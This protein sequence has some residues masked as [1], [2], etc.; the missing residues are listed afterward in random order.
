MPDLR[1]GI[2]TSPLA[3]T[4]AGTARY[5]EALL[6]WLERD[7]ALEV[8]RYHFGAS[9]RPARIARDVGWYLAALPRLARRDGVDV[10]HCP[11]FRAPLRSPLPLV[12]TVH[13][14]AVLRHPE[15]FNRWARSYG[16]LTLPQVA[17]SATAIIAVSE[18]TKGEVVELLGVPAQRV[19]VVRHGVARPFEPEG[20]AGD[21]DYVLAV[22]TIEPR[23]NLARLLDG[24]RR[25]ALNGTELR[26]AGARGWGD[27]RV[28]AEG[29]RWLGEV[30]DEELARLYRGARCLAYV[31]LYEGFGLPI[32]EAMA[33]GTPVVTTGWG[34]CAEVAGD[35]AVL[36]DALDPDAIG[37]GL[38]EAAQ[39]HDELSSK[40][41]KRAREFTWK[42]AAG[43]TADV[44]RKAAG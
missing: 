18:F 20:P 7:N 13:D 22:S 8:V 26:I 33:C 25:A 3:L 17:R 21:G 24:F 2:D 32:L 41:Q 16:R 9:G 36:V 15:A 37:A 12:V 1:V 42:Q 34:A 35:A 43:A 39:R 5:L 10:L 28:E 6:E 44:Y 14:L 23:K 11:T 4:R 29:V 31:S 30:R 38:A 40:G 19:H 27:V